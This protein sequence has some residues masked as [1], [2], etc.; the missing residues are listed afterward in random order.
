MNS[1]WAG[2]RK[3]G[4]LQGARLKDASTDRPGAFAR[5]VD[6][7]HVKREQMPVDLRFANPDGPMP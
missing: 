7:H 3:A 6:Y 5:F 2:R 1:K 4:A